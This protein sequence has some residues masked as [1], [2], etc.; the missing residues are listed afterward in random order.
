MM[1]MSTFSSPGSFSRFSEEKMLKDCGEQSD[2]VMRER[3][4][5]GVLGFLLLTLFT[6]KA[7]QNQVAFFIIW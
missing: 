4:N 1:L 2:E 7:H 6:I 5:I 3:K